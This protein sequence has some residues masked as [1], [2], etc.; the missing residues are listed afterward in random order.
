MQVIAKVGRGAGFGGVLG[1]VYGPGKAEEHEDPRIVGGCT[2]AQ[3]RRGIARELRETAAQNE[4]AKTPVMHASLRLPPEERDRLD[5]E[6]WGK[7]AGSWMQQMGYRDEDGR[8]LAPWTAIRHGEDHVHIVGS[9]IG[10]DGKSIPSSFERRR[11]H[12]ACRVVEREHGLSAPDDRRS[13]G[14]MQTVTRSERDSAQRRGVQPERA[15]LRAGMDR[16]KQQAKSREDFEKRCAR[17]GI[18]LKA[19]TAKNGRMNGYSASLEGWNDK[20]GEP[21][22]LPASKV[23]KS[24]SWS[25]LGPQIEQHRGRELANERGRDNEQEM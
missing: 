1:Y 8:D 11:S 5:D 12:E 24:L 20:D 15:Q 18:S 10:Y 14:R 21:V 3:D 17:E 4:R 7:A 2:V 22:W 9:R 16:A 6:A 23:H 19:N 13:R 25:Q